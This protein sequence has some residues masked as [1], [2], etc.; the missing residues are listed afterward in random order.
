MARYIDKGSPG[1]TT[2]GGVDL[3]F[4]PEDADSGNGDWDELG[5]LEL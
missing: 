2:F 5:T 3:F 1:M 4:P